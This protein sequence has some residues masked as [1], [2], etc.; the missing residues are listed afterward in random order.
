MPACHETS[1]YK[2]I[3]YGFSF[4]FSFVSSTVSSRTWK[5]S[6]NHVWREASVSSCLVDC[7][8]VLLQ[9]IPWLLL[10]TQSTLLQLSW[11]I[12]SWV[13]VRKWDH[14]F[15]GSR[16]AYVSSK[17]VSSLCLLQKSPT[18]VCRQ[19]LYI[20]I[21][22]C[23]SYFGIRQRELWNKL[24]ILLPQGCDP[25]SDLAPATVGPLH[26]ACFSTGV[27][28]LLVLEL[29]RVHRTSFNRNADTRLCPSVCHLLMDHP[30]DPLQH[31]PTAWW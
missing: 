17:I 21:S 15:W 20:Y 6:H 18:L 22:G 29:G 4:H 26:K 5:W 14:T 12:S 27:Q 3:L 2:V 30:V 16:Y 7:T 10:D 23:N 13:S 25:L 24:V 31:Q 19:E 8:L 28:Q 9:V 11:R 1:V